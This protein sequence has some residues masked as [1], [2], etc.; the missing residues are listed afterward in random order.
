MFVSLQVEG[1]S[2]VVDAVGVEP[3]VLREGL[4]DSSLITG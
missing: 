1:F 2:T 4:G 3:A